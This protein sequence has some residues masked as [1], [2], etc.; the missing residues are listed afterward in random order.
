MSEEKETGGKGDVASFSQ[1][2]ESG[3]KLNS[4]GGKENVKIQN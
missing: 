3:K 2:S 4:K 1:G